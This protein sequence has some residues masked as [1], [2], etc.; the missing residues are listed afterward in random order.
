MNLYFEYLKSFQRITGF[1]GREIRQKRAVFFKEHNKI[2]FY[3]IPIF[4][5]SFN[6]LSYLQGI[7]SRLEEMGYK[8]LK[9]IDNA[10][11]YPPLLEYYNETNYEVFRMES[12]YGHMVFWKSEVFKKYREDLY[13]V[14][15]PDVIP[16]DECPNDFVELF[17]KYLRK[18][19]R[20]KKAGFSLKIDDIPKDAPLYTDVNKWERAYNFFKIPFKN[21][22]TADIDTTFALYIP[23]SIDISRRFLV[24]IRTGYPYQL[25]HLPWYKMPNEVTEEDKYY[26]DHRT[27]GFWDATVGKRTGEGSESDWDK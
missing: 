17:Y 26:S 5:I 18:Y 13:V 8:N 2:D 24:A 6:R 3:N 12:N 14:T 7:I 20:I 11:T 22:Y 23:D 27:N 1:V 25:K 21:A 19:P 16:L 15:D 4:I 10:S 9:I